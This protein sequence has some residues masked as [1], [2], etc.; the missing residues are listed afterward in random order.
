MKRDVVIVGGGIVGCA[1]A[2]FAAQAGLNVTLVER[3]T[4]GYGASSRNPGFLWLHCRSAGF[5]LDISR[6]GRA[7]CGRLLDELPGGFE[8]RP[9]GGLMYFTTPGEGAVFEEFVASRRR[10]G[11]DMELIDGGEVR[12]LV[13]PVREDVLGAS[14]CSEDAQ[15]VTASLIAALAR[16]A[17]AEGATIHEGVAVERLL[18]S[19]G[20]AAGVETEIGRISADAVVVTTGAWTTGFMAA[21]GLNIPIGG[22]RL[23]LVKTPPQP[24]RIEPLVYGPLATRQYALF[25]DLPSWDPSLFRYEREGNGLTLLPLL[26]QQ[27]SGEVVMGCATDY[28][29][30]IDP[31]ATLG[32]LSLLANGMGREYPSLAN[33][34][35]TA[36]WA[37]ALPFTSD[38]K[39]VIDEVGPG[40]FVGAGHAFGNT[41]GLVTAEV[42]TDLL[43]RRPPSFE[44]EECRADRPLEAIEAGVA[45]HW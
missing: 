31:V 30:E 7:I 14:Y 22:E 20:A 4:L 35:I 39:P 25:R 15:I 11:L 6:A 28:P 40:V 12:R 21:E 3:E 36:A 5:D 19:S 2:Y 43:L 18:T 32:G 10:D 33:V 1:T 41:A 16:G 42:L 13:P 24:F 8:F 29:D 44:I 34:P 37:G 26:V 9:A 17:R 38:Q 45:T 27:A 23:Q